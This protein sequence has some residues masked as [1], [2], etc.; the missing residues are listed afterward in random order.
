MVKEETRSLTPK[1]CAVLDL[2]LD[3]IK[4][5]DAPLDTVF[6]GGSAWHKAQGMI[7]NKAP[8]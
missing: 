1:Q 3:T 4:V 2:A 8:K 6:G 7:S 5:S